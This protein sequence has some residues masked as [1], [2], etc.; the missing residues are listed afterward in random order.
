MSAPPIIMEFLTGLFI[1]PI[2]TKNSVA[3]L[4]GAIIEILSPSSIINSPFGMIT[5]SPRSTIHTRISHF[6]L[7]P[8]SGNLI[9]CKIEPLL[10][11]KVNSSTFPLLNVFISITDGKR[12]IRVIS[13]AASY[14]GLIAI[15]NPNS[16]LINPISLL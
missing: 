3:F 1:I 8:I 6:N 10:T 16:S 13:R 14:S 12:S 15:D 2:F 4:C 11:L 5:S 9:L 7:L